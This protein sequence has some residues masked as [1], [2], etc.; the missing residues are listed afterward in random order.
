MTP[1]PKYAMFKAM[2][3]RDPS[4][5]ADHFS[6]RFDLAVVAL[7]TV[8][9]AVFSVYVELN[10]ALFAMTRRW[11]TLQLDEL[12]VTLLALTVCLAW[13]AWRRFREAR[14]QLAGLVP[15]S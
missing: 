10:E 2:Q 4:R 5:Q 11:E 12:P 6:L 15:R 13:F 9:M 8:S 14:R 3:D 1:E 7:V